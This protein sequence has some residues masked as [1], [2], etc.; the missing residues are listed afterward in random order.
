MDSSFS[1][2]QKIELFDLN[3]RQG[4]FKRLKELY[5]VPDDFLKPDTK[6]IYF[7]LGKFKKLF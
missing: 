7:S 6:L 1:P 5:E 4:R 2:T 3:D